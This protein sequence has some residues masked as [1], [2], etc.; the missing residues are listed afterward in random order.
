[1]SK[2]LL[3]PHMSEQIHLISKFSLKVLIKNQDIIYDS[4][5]KNNLW[6]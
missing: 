3:Y 6:K 2:W 5:I 1:M 4:I